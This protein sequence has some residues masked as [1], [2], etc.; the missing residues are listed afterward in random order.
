MEGRPLI[1][2]TNDDGVY[3]EG[4][5]A[6]RRALTEVARTVV[7]AP[8]VERSASS[9]SITLQRPLR[10]K[11][12]DADLFALD[13]TPVDCVF[14]ALYSECFLPR[15][16]DLV[17]SGINH[18]LNLGTDTLYSGTV[19]AAREAAIHGISAMALSYDDTEGFS[20]IAD[21]CLKLTCRLLESACE[22]NSATLLNVNF[23]KGPIN[24]GLT[25]SLA[26]RYYQDHVVARHDPRG[27]EYL[28]IGGRAIENK[29]EK[30]TDALAVK[31]GFISITALA[32][33]AIDTNRLEVAEKLAASCDVI[34][35]ASQSAE[36]DSPVNG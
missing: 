27:R 16:P 5:T 25:T 9:H 6:L 28:W 18:G 7:V 33:E 2:L 36:G 8:A 14:M 31:Q 21:I 11:Q 26:R 15:R 13:G 24:G 32:I 20:R 19:G 30:G 29:V 22:S 3:A 1:L 34:V 35:N 10:H 17:L 12:L 4:L 23:P